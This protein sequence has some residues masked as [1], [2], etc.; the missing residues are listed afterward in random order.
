MRQPSGGGAESCGCRFTV[1]FRRVGVGFLGH[2][3]P[4]GE[5]RLPHGRPTAET[6]AGPQRGCHVA[7]E[8]DSTG[9]GAP[10]TPGTVVRS[11]PA[12]V[13]RP[14]PAAFQR[15]VPTAPLTHPIGGGHLHEASSGVHLRS[16][17]TPRRPAAAPEPGSVTGFPPVF[18]SP[19]APRWNGTASASTPG[20][21][22]RSHPQSTPGRRQ[23]LAHWPEYYTYGISR[24]SKRCLPLHS[25]TLMSHPP[26]RGLQHH[27]RRSAP[28]R[29]ITSASRSQV[30][31]IRTVS[32]C[33]P[34][35]V[36]RTRSP[37]PNGADADPCR[38]TVDP[39][40]EF[41]HRGLLRRGTT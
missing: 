32:R 12:A 9:Q 21:A 11:R 13:L 40:V 24:T 36:I 4:A 31:T 23:A 18:S 2:P 15:P 22:P 29:V 34:V 19:A 27:L 8:Q 35:S 38:Q 20:F 33:S 26:V 25:C 5:L 39:L 28:A 3:A 17:I 16:P 6:I 30:L 41:V 1:A 14:A 10:F 37:P 7:H